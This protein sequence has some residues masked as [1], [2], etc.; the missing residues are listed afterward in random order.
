VISAAVVFPEFIARRGKEGEDNFV[1]RVFIPE[2]FE[3]RSSLFE[4]AHGCAMHPNY[5]CGITIQGA[6][7]FPNEAFAPLD[8]FFRFRMKRA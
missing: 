8:S 7:D 5:R 2:F 3:N 6:R 1:V 4:L